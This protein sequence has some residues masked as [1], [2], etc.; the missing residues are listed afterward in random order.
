MAMTVF[1]NCNIAVGPGPGDTIHVIIVDS[2]DHDKKYVVPLTKDAAN[3][4]AQTLRQ[5]T[6]GLVVAGANELPKENG[7]GS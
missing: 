5:A 2:E 3:Q 1:E 6:S 7:N 4:I